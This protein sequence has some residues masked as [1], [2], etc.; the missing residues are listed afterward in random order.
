VV[1]AMARG[2]GFAAA[3]IWIAYFRFFSAPI[4]NVPPRFTDPPAAGYAGSTAFGG[5]RLQFR[6]NESDGIVDMRAQ[7][8]HTPPI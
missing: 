4:P 8:L 3:P 2:R 5:H 1:A 6:E 7:D